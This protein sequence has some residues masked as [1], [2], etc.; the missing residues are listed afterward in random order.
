MVNPILLVYI[1]S[2]QS[3]RCLKGNPIK[4]FNRYYEHTIVLRKHIELKVMG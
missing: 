4:K 2:P 3:L 1:D